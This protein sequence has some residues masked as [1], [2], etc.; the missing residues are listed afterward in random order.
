MDEQTKVD[1]PRTINELIDLPYSEM[2][3]EEI[4]LVVEFKAAVKARDA[5]HEARMSALHDALAEQTEIHRVMADTAQA[6]LE[7]LT[8]HAIGRFEDAS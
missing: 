8:A 5:E 1:E 4:A 7:D 2:T 3:E 6:K